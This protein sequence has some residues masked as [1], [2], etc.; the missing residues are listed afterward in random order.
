MFM[1]NEKCMFMFIFTQRSSRRDFTAVL[2]SVG[3]ILKTMETFTQSC[4]MTNVLREQVYL[5][6]GSESYTLNLAKL[7]YF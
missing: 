4:D 1:T 3:R 5:S 2:F 7:N 6:K